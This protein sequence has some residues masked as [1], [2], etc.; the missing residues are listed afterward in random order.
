MVTTTSELRKYL[1][2][3]EKTT[4][5]ILME[6]Y[7][8]LMKVSIDIDTKYLHILGR[9]LLAFDGFWSKFEGPFFFVE[10]GSGCQEVDYTFSCGFC[11]VFNPAV[12]L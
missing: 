11:K 7:S 9:S 12:I 5:R 6:V 4:Q 10:L 2:L 3:G 8:E 1:D